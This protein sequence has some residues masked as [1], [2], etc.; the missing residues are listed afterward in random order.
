MELTSVSIQEK[1]VLFFNTYLYLG[2]RK[3]WW[4]C[5]SQVTDFPEVWQKVLQLLIRA[6]V[7]IKQNSILRIQQMVTDDHRDYKALFGQD[8]NPFYY[9]FCSVINVRFLDMRFSLILAFMNYFE[10]CKVLPLYLINI[11]NK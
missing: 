1:F 11:S 5:K 7:N 2:R 9:S 3:W 6:G 4:N 8:T 10:R